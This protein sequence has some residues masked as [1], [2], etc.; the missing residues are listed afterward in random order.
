[1]SPVEK[2]G[3]EAFERGQHTRAR[4]TAAEDRGVVWLETRGYQVI[5]RNVE[6]PAGEIDVVALDGD[7][8]C[9][10]EIK[11]RATRSHGPAVAAVDRRKQARIGR[12]AALYLA[13]SAWEGACRFDV[14]GM[15]ADNGGWRYS[16]VRDAFQ[17]A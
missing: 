17:L 12:A 3:L 1:M 11:A 2:S 16:L 8:L 5:E 14:L 10:V 15:D 9:F 7:V 4:G 13:R 6:T